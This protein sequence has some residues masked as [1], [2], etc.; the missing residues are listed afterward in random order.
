MYMCVYVHVC[1]GLTLRRH[2][3]RPVFVP[4]VQPSPLLS[5]DRHVETAVQQ[6]ALHALVSTSRAAQGVLTPSTDARVWPCAPLL[7]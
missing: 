3:S 2:P 6:Q 1:A 5:E 7:G 4:L